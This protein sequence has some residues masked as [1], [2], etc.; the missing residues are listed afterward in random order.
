MGF[1]GRKKY[2]ML[3]ILSPTLFERPL[4]QLIHNIA[5]DEDPYLSSHPLNLFK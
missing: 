2:E 5:A 1:V 3:Q 4:N